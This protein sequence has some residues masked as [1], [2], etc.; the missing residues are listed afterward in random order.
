ML[1]S[2]LD[3]E[4]LTRTVTFCAYDNFPVAGIYLTG[5]NPE[6]AKE[7]AID[8]LRKSGILDENGNLVEPYNDFSDNGFS[9]SLKKN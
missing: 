7:I 6:K 1:L 4:Y 3:A 5:V 2:T 8:S 9:K